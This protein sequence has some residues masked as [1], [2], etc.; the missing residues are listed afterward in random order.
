MVGLAWFE[1]W[2]RHGL[3][4]GLPLVCDNAGTALS[5]TSGLQLTG[6]NSDGGDFGYF[7][8]FGVKVTCPQGGGTKVVIPAP[9]E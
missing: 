8:M 1:V 4:L 7:F 9:V 5:N 3:P 6:L 2:L